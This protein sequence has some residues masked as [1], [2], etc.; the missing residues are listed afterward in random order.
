MVNKLFVADVV[1]TISACDKVEIEYEG[2]LVWRFDC[3]MKDDTVKSALVD[4]D[5]LN[6]LQKHHK[7][8]CE[9]R[10]IVFDE[11]EPEDEDGY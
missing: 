6:Y 2:G 5:D 7:E 8:L 11:D 4:D 10:G 1:N 3:H 9:S